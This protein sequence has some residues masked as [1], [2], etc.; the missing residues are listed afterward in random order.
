MAFAAEVFARQSVAKF[1]HDLRNAQHESQ[2]NPVLGLE[3]L[4][5]RGQ[6]IVKRVKLDGHQ[7]Q[8]RERQQPA[9][10]DGRQGK[11]PPNLGIHPTEKA[12]RI[13]ALESNREDV[14]EGGAGLFPLFFPAAFAKLF[15]L[16]GDAGDHQGALMEP[17]DELPQ[18]LDRD[19]LRRKAALE[20]DFDLVEARLTV[21]HLQDRV[22]FF[23]K[24]EVLQPDRLLDYPIHLALVA[25][26]FGAQV[27]PHPH[28]QRPCGTGDQTVVQG[29]HGRLGGAV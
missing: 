9:K 18:F 25:L 28:A 4:M 23:L 14:A 3:E 10:D 11:E 20:L 13:G 26:V 17:A 15:T 22:L 27:G 19:L 5:E 12:I 16:T 2:V 1:V 24:A 21:E 29:D 6:F 8:C 7:Q